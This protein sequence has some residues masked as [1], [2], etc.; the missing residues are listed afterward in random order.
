LRARVPISVLERVLDL[1]G[2]SADSG[3]VH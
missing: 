2:V 1:A 3:P